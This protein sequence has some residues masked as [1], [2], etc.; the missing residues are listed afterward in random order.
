VLNIVI[1]AAGKGS[2]MHS[3][4]PKVLHE[5]AGEP[6]LG[7]VISVAKSLVQKRGGRIRV[8][9]G[10]GSD[11]VDP[12]V[13]EQGA[14]IVHQR[15]Q[16]GTG[17]ALQIA[18]DGL[19]S[20]GQTLVLYG[21]VPLISEEDIDPLIAAGESG[22]A[23]L[24]AVVGDPTGYGR[25]IRDTTGNVVSIV[26]HRDASESE[27]AISEINSGIYAAPTSLFQE[28]LPLLTNGNA[29]NEYYL[30]DCVQ[31]SVNSGREVYGVEGAVTA[32]MG[33][34]DRLQ[35]AE[36]NQ[37][38]Q[39]ER[40]NALMS[41]GVTLVAPETVYLNGSD[42]HIQPDTIIEPNV[43]LNSPVSIG[44]NVQIGFGSHLTNVVIGDGS[45]I[46]PYTVAES[47]S[48]G[49]NAQVGPFTR[50]RPGTEL[51]DA[52]HVGNFCETKNAKVGEGSKI[53]HLSYVGDAVIG[54]RVNVGAGTITCN[55]D[56]A[57]KHQTTLG[58]DVFVGSNTSLI[59]PVTLGDGVTTGA[60][61]VI[62]TDVEQQHLALARSK[63]INI[64]AYQRPKKPKD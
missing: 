42:I 8:V 15:Q 17:H 55:Y 33:V 21:D 3:S 16:L 30:T 39:Q 51:S 53:N 52:T 9:T 35:L 61:S 63:Q 32:T 40:R 59:A 11:Q 24:T 54:K 20:E 56:G 58:D 45:V 47:A 13:L 26:E 23:V 1:L 25:I 31:L 27:R 34:N 62:T 29:Q 4:L 60:G 44:S 18:M 37:L 41:A 36:L 19:A 10:H 43:T 6:L 7:H 57:Y 48:V 22:L 64:P 5:L 46:K 50:L 2:R 38:L 12:F 28:L 14:E 49:A